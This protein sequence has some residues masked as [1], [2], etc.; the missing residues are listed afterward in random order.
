MGVKRTLIKLINKLLRLRQDASHLETNFLYP[1]GHF[2]SPIIS[3]TDIRG[4]EH[5]IWNKLENEDI[6]GIEQ[7]PT[8]QLHL[9]NQ[10]S[11]Y[12]NEIPFKHGKL[13]QVRYYFDN[14]YYSYTDGIILYS[15]IR[16][17]KPKQ[18][19]EIGSGFSSAVMLD[20]NELFFD[21][22]IDL[23]FIEPYPDRLL[24]LLTEDDHQQTKIIKEDIQ[25]VPLDTFQKLTAGDILFI[26]SSHVVKTGS[27]V[28]FILFKILPI[29]K[30]GVLIHFHDIFYPFEYPKD[31]IFMGRNW[32]EIYF[33]KAF[34][35]YNTE[36]EILLF[37]DYLHKFYREFFSAM[38]LCYHNCGGNIWIEKK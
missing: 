25:S 3:V 27:D 20:T 34:L 4:R 22:Q 38:P 7:R 31:W 37:S 24:S 28:N 5:E 23:T 10:L 29:L 6:I 36:F 2:Y 13:Q 33:L 19:I 14:D 32:N 17:F 16:H 8:V 30:K 21:N 15:I 26:D 11:K 35:M 9:L 12:Y 18:I 1:S